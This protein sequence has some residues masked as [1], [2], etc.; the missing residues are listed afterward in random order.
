MKR[1]AK[2]AAHH[3]PHKA[4]KPHKQEPAKKAAAAKHPAHHK[5]KQQPAGHVRLGGRDR[6]DKHKGPTREGAAPMKVKIVNRPSGILNGQPWPEVGEEID[7]PDIVAEGMA[8]AGAVE[9]VKAKPAKKA[10][11][12]K[13]ETATASKAKVETRKS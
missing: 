2:K 4:H 1:P 9:I 12:K 5:H 11:A 7:L 8:D 3:K 10:A 13:A 6:F